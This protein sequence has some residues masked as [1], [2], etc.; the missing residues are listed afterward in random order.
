MK[1]RVVQDT[2]GPYAGKWVVEDFN[3]RVLDGPFPDEASA[4]HE[5]TMREGRGERMDEV[6]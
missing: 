4:R 6:Y 1:Y 2:K 3:G 5:V